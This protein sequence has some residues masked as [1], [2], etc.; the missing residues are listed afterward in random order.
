[1]G[2]GTRRRNHIIGARDRCDGTADRIRCVRTKRFKYIRN[3]F[4]NRPYTQFNLYKKHRYTMWALMQILYAEDK[5]TQQQQLFMA[6]T[7][8]E[9]EFYDLRTDPHELNNL[10]DVPKHNN[11]LQS[12]RKILD[13]WS[14]GTDD[15]G[16]ICEDPSIGV[17]AYKDV[18][19]YYEPE[20][21][22]RGLPANAP[23][24]E[25]LK[26]WQKTLFPNRTKKQAEK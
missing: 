23:P 12:L 14:K 18:Q 16:A 6:S 2:A 17:K 1:M 10:A 19:E 21:K 11:L 3:Y 26:Y 22:K 20:Q 25:Y 24:T 7:R 9:E 8:P 5:L 15:K 4:P 13:K